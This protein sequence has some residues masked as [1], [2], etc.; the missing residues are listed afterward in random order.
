[1]ADLPA[2]EAVLAAG[3]R[4]VFTIVHFDGYAAVLVQLDLVTKPVLRRLLTDAWLAKVP[5]S[6][7][8]SY[9]ARPGRRSTRPRGKKGL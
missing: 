8:A 9:R 1:V 7:S 6:M 3:T 5:P 4:G 2:K